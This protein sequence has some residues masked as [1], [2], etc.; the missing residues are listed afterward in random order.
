MRIQHANAGW[1]E[2]AAGETA[3]LPRVDPENPYGFVAVAAGEG[4]ASLFRDLGCDQVVSGGQTM[5]PST[6]D[7]LNAI[8]ATPAKVVY[9][10]PITRT[11]SWPPNR[12][13]RWRIGRCMSSLPAPSRRGFPPC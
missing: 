10:L 1:V 7:I 13:C 3:A 12:R 4:L 6:D 2:E 5:N 9:V 8:Q 11:S